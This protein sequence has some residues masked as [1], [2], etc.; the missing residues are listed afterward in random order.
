MFSLLQTDRPV[1]LLDV[2]YLS[3]AGDNYFDWVIE[4]AELES[5]VVV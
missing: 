2:T 3:A 5:Q 1:G 4:V